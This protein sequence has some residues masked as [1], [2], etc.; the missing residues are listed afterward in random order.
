M[1]PGQDPHSY[2]PSSGDLAAAADADVIFVNGWDLEEGLV[3]NLENV[4]ERGLL[5][6]ISG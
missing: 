6:P 2:E 3:G 4:N 5:V 1:S